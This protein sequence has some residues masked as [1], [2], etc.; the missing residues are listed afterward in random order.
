M[1]LPPDFQFA[2]KAF[3]RHLENHPRVQFPQVGSTYPR[4]PEEIETRLAAIDEQLSLIKGAYRQELSRHIE[5]LQMN[6]MVPPR[7]PL[8]VLESIDKRLFKLQRTYGGTP[9]WDSSDGSDEG[10]EPGWFRKAVTGL[11]DLLGGWPG[12]HNELVRQSSDRLG[13]IYEPH[14]RGKQAPRIFISYRR[15][16]NPYATQHIHGRL[17]TYFGRDEVFMDIDSMPIGIDFVQYLT[18]ALGKCDIFLAVIGDRW[19]GA[20]FNDG[21]LKG[22]RRLEDANDVVRIEIR[23]AL[24]RM[25][26]VVPLLVGMATMPSEQDLPE[27]L[28][29]LARMNA[30]EVRPGRDMHEHMN[31]LIRSIEYIWLEESP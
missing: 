29:Q 26:P 8:A 7:S 18:N 16:D 15:L 13:D 11:R 25:I 24:A 6:A 22:Q 17:A 31:R 5:S 21:P 30:A 14:K 28:K 2:V 20:V 19:L 9:P 10:Q 3:F 1:R 4:L 23:L 27:D 12:G